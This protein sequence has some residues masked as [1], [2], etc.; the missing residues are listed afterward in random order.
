MNFLF[1]YSFLFVVI[2]GN[3]LGLLEAKKSD[4]DLKS[5]LTLGSLVGKT[6]NDAILN[7]EKLFNT[8]SKD[9]QNTIIAHDTPARRKRLAAKKNRGRKPVQEN[10]KRPAQKNKNTRLLGRRPVPGQRPRQMRGQR[11]QQ[12]GQQGNVIQ[13]LRQR[14]AELQEQRQINA[15]IREENLEEERQNFN[16]NQRQRIRERQA[17]MRQMREN[18]RENRRLRRAQLEAT[19]AELVELAREEERSLFAELTTTTTPTTTATTPRGP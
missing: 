3:A 1:I 10:A 5:S 14:I 16:L 13:Q 15:I 18:R 12:G 19:V 8:E 17:R 9:L 7:D 4:D 11:R 6:F 2:C